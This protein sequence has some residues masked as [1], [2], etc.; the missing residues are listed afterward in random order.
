M[1][2]TIVEDLT[3]PGTVF[4]G[5]AGNAAEKKDQTE[6]SSVLVK[7]CNPNVACERGIPRLLV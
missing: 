1:M 2:I 5:G 3:K 6:I 7:L 4:E